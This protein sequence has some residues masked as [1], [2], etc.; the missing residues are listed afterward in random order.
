MRNLSRWE[1]RCHNCEESTR[2]LAMTLKD[3]FFFTT[4]SLFLPRPSRWERQWQSSMDG[5]HTLP[6]KA[7]N[8]YKYW[9]QQNGRERRQRLSPS[10]TTK[11]AQKQPT[12]SVISV[13]LTGYWWIFFP[14]LSRQSLAW[15]LKA[16]CQKINNVRA[17]TLH[18][19]GLHMNL[20]RLSLSP[21][22]TLTY[23]I[24]NNIYTKS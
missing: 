1:M 3:S 13:C 2:W 23:I 16:R 4:V 22:A 15:V 19:N 18:R 24:V 20:G 11:T 9:T 6:R 14:S 7:K 10:R 12:R 8:K 5:L 21:S 17:P